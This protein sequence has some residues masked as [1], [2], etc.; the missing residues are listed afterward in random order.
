MFVQVIQGKTH[1]AAGLQRQ[2][3]RWLDELGSGATGFLGTTGGVAD[4]GTAVFLARFETED[5]AR[6]NSGRPEQGAW[7]NETAICFDGDVVFRDCRKVDVTLAGA[8]DQAGFVQVMQGSAKDRAR[9]LA[10]EA[11]L[12]PRLVE[13]RPDVIGSVRA[14]DGDH[15]TDAIYFTSEA[16]A[17]A[18]EASM[19][20]GTGDAMTELVSLVEDLT[21]VDLKDPWLHSAP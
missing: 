11:E 7:W 4:D 21:F 6:A 9:L 19:A 20:A 2:F 16:A 12:M 8:S 18:G 13:L 5:A 3:E 10:L 1:D 17:R 15:F 14:W